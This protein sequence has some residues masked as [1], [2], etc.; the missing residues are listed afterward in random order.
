MKKKLIPNKDLVL[1][2]IPNP[3]DKSFEYEEPWQE[4]ALTINAYE[5]C[6][7]SES[8]FETRNK[9]FNDPLN[10]SLTEL[11]CALFV[12]QRHHRWNSPYPVPGEDERIKQLLQLIRN[13]VEKREFE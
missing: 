3:E 9:V 8:A 11:R 13:K 12:L 4:F 1:E 5:V 10:A 2:K 6:G 7:N